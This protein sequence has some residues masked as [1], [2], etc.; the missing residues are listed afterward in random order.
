MNKQKQDLI[1]CSKNTI[2]VII[3]VKNG[4]KGIARAIQGLL[5]QSIKPSEIIIVDG[6]S[7]DSTAELASQFPVTII[8][9]DYGSVGGARQ[10]GL[11]S[12]SSNYVA[13]TDADCIPERE[14][15]QNLVDNFTEEYVGVGGG[16]KNIGKDIWSEAVSYA[17]NSFLGSAN[18]VQDRVFEEKRIVKSLSGCN[19]LYRKNDLIKIGGFN[20]KLRLNEDTE[21]NLRLSKFGKLLYVPNANILHDQDRNIRDFARRIYSFG[22]GRAK[23]KLIDLQVIPPILALLSVLILF[24]NKDVFILIIMIYIVILVA[25]T[26]RIYFRSKKLY[27]L[28]LVPFV[29]FLEHT[30]YIA[31][32]W[33]GTVENIMHLFDIYKKNS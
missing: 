8:Y 32:F 12:A 29:Y 21:L 5:N 30:T 9:E 18:S 2:S 13:F 1:R 33:K 23:N 22:Y 7:T 26:F 24:L 3:P 16:V 14:W 27:L 10:V 15:L 11:E 31:G 17:L 28:C 19:C 20:T 25:F 6:H 4:E